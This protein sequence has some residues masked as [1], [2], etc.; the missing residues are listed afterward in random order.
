[1]FVYIGL[2]FRLLWIGVQWFRFNLRSLI[3]SGS[4]GNDNFQ[5]KLENFYHWNDW[6]I[7]RK[8]FQ[9]I[10]R[11]VNVHINATFGSK[12]LSNRLKRHRFELQN[13]HLNFNF[14][15]IS[16]E[17]QVK[18]YYKNMLIYTVYI[19]QFMRL[20]SSLEKE[21]DNERIRDFY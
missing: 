6:I 19:K 11:H 15:L 8:I 9:R 20:H 2:L 18:T 16:I 5:L 1:M 12:N 3:F 14:N 13:L 21:N 10:S 17:L 4:F 7:R